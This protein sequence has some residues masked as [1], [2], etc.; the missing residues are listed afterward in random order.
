MANLELDGLKSQFIGN[1]IF[2]MVS[3]IYYKNMLEIM[4]YSIRGSASSEAI[5]GKPGNAGS[6]NSEN[7]PPFSLKIN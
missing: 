4:T 1:L 6:G 7:L 2:T 5:Y 3:F